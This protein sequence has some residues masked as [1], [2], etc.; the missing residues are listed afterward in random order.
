MVRPD[1]FPKDPRNAEFRA[2]NQAVRDGEI[3]GFIVETVATL[4]GVKRSDRAAYLCGVR[5]NVSVVENE[6]DG[7]IKVSFQI[8]PKPNHH[9]GI[10]PILEDRVR[11]ALALS[12]KLLKVPRIEQPSPPITQEE[13][14]YPAQTSADKGKRLDRTFAA[15]RE[16][17]PRGVGKQQIEALGSTISKRVGR[18]GPWWANLDRATQAEISQIASAVGEWADADSI[19]AH[20]GYQ[21]ELFCTEDQ[22]ITAGSSILNDAN[23]GWLSNKYGIRFVTLAE[24]ASMLK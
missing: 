6:Q 2:L 14:N 5:P 18:A 4:E 24:L 23:R 12:F 19:A 20:I 3:A 10:A 7:T 22:G 9:P 8:G 17:E 15:L 21:N 13:A 1:K 11:E 16:I